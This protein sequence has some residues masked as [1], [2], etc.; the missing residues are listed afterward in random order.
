MLDLVMS[1]PRLYHG[2]DGGLT[3]D[4]KASNLSCM[5]RL[6]DS[7]PEGIMLRPGLVLTGI[8]EARMLQ[9]PVRHQADEDPSAARQACQM[10][11]Y[12]P[13]CSSCAKKMQARMCR[14]PSSLRIG[15]VLRTSCLSLP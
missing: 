13:W 11:V 1:F 14:M 8:Q 9:N 3:L 7:T 4:N 6:G 15:A 10:T 12:V 2:L 5:L